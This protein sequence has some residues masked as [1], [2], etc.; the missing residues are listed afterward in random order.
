MHYRMNELNLSTVGIDQ[1]TSSSVANSLTVS[2]SHLG[3]SGSPP[4]NTLPAPGLPVAIPNLGPSLSSLPSALSVMLPMGIGDRGVM[5][6]LPE[7]NYPLPPP[8]YPHL[9][10]SYF[11]HILPGILSY[12]ADRPPPQYIHP[13]PLNVDGN[14]G[15]SVSNAPQSL[16]PF[17]PG[18]SVGLETGIVS[19][20]SRSVGGHTGQSL[21]PSDGH[22]VQLDSGITMGSVSRVNSPIPSDGITEELAM[23]GVASEHRQLSNVPRSHEP[24][25]V[26]GSLPPD[27]VGHASVLP[28]HSGSLELPVVMESEHHMATRS[29][30]SES[31]LSDTIHTVAMDS[32]PV[33]VALSSSHQLSSLT[34]VSLHGGSISLEPVTVSSI[35]PE[36]SMGGGHVDTGNLTFVPS[37]L[38]IDSNSNKEN[39]ATLF[40]IWC[41]LCDRAYPSDCPEHGPVTFIPDNPIE[42]RARLSLPKELALRQSVTGAEMGVWAQE[43]IPVRTC[44]GPLIGQESQSL[45]VADWTDK[46]ASHIWKMYHNGVMEFCIIT[47]D[48]NECN[49]MMFVRKARN[50]EE[51]NL[52]AYPHDGKIYFCT[53]HNV[54][55]EQELL[56]YYSRDYAR[57]MGLPEQPEFFVCHCGK[58]CHSYADFKSHVN[59]H[60]PAEPL[61]SGVANGLTPTKERKWKCSMCSRSFISSSKLNVHFMGHM[62]MKPHKCEFCSKAFSDP[63]N[64]RTHL[65]IHTGQKNY[66]C[67]LCDKS[68]TQKAHLASH[69]AIHTG[70]K[71]L[72]CDFCEKMFMR[73]H[74]LKQH[75]LTHTRERRIRCPKCD[76]CFSRTGHL[77]KHLNSHEGRRDYVCEKCSKAFLTRYHLS[78]HLKICKGPSTAPLTP[79]TDEEEDSEDEELLGSDCVVFN[80]DLTVHT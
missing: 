46:S 67:G 74:D 9:E 55:P 7:R 80:T 41:T 8:P 49:W 71:T 35:T 36:V 77:K 45:E 23:E 26:D 25:T 5:C 17:Q 63:S 40:T 42:S 79:D 28:L 57:Q 32:N 68:F 76:K 27:A 69:M 51:Q 6:G 15:L 54:S 58:E 66:R 60:L 38:Q 44:F 73:R 65:R 10:S 59:S 20:D 18:G 48:E 39:M 24:L 33:T 19:L 52:V 64:L 14:S 34:S 56:F 62:G 53:S 1:L 2:G 11:R 70:E 29:S 78:R 61:S 16:D 13:S 12:L 75:V 22:E 47:T 21:H 31:S 4:H 37:T 3:L 50:P 30:M 72:K 43:T